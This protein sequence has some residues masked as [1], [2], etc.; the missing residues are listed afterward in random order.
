MII[1]Q[2]PP[3]EQRNSQQS[4][5]AAWAPKIT[6]YKC[7]QWLR[8]AMLRRWGSGRFSSAGACLLQARLE[9]CRWERWGLLI[10]P[11]VGRVLAIELWRWEEGRRN[12]IFDFAAELGLGVVRTFSDRKDRVRYLICLPS[13]IAGIRRAARREV[14]A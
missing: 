10:I 1:H 12:A 5:Q 8:Y 2:P 14:A 4:P 13:H 7:P 9:P 3:P 11:R 6:R